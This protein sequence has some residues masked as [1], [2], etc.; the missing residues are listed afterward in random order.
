MKHF[1][2]IGPCNGAEH[3][4]VEA[5][6]RLEGVERMIEKARYFV[7]HAAR[8][9]GKTTCLLDLRDRF[10]AAGRHYVVYCS[11]ESLKNADD[12]RNGI[13]EIV[14]KLKEAF[15]NSDL[16]CK[17]EFG[18]DIKY[19]KYV[20][21]LNREL[22]LF[23]VSADKPLVLLFDDVDRLSDDTFMAFLRQ[24]RDGY[25]SRLIVSFVHSVALVGT[26]NVRDFKSRIRPYR[27]TSGAASPFNVIARTFTV[28]NFS[29]EEISDLFRPYTAETGRRFERSAVERIHELTLGHPWAVNALAREVAERADDGGGRRPVTVESVDDALQSLVTRRD[30]NLVALLEPLKEERV[31]KIVEPMIAGGTVATGGLADDYRYAVDSGLIRRDAGKTVPSNPVCGELIVRALSAGYRDEIVATL[32]ECRLSRYLRD[33]RLDVDSMMRDFQRFRRET[34]SAR[35]DRLRY[36]DVA[37]HLSLVAFLQSVADDGG[38]IRVETSSDTDRMD[39]CIVCEGRKYPVAIT[40]RNGSATVAEGTERMA[41]HLA[42]LGCDEGWLAVFDRRP[43]VKWDDKLFVEKVAVDGKTVTV[44]GL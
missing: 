21:L 2:E 17:A 30:A 3:Y 23:C 11:L 22:T 26:R 39:L 9:S 12:S 7:V 5:S 40:V 32:G 19:D 25:N 13:P 15:E 8:R 37:L 24:L 42:S 28:R 36:R 33:G 10:N 34:V 20:N 14:G 27:E 35:R 41:K 16:P 1:N 29:V 6:T 4:T 18:K 44:V 38:R 31:R 43:K